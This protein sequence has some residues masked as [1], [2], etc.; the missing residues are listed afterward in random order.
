MDLDHLQALMGDVGEPESAASLDSQR[1]IWVAAG[2]NRETIRKSS[3]LLTPARELAT[4]L[5]AY[6]R[7]VL[8]GNQLEN[9][10]EEFIQL[11]ADGV[12]LVDNP[13]LAS[14]A[15]E[16]M[17]DVLARLFQEHDPAVVLF[18]AGSWGDPLAAGL[19]QR[20]R[21]PLTAG[22]VAL[23]PDLATR[24]ISAEYVVYGGEYYESRSW[25]PDQASRAGELAQLFTLMPAAYRSPAPDPYRSGSVEPVTVTPGSTQPRVRR[26][27][28]ADHQ[29][30]A[31]PIS[32]ASRLVAVGFDLGETNLPAAQALADKLGAQLCGDRTAAAAGWISYNQVVGLTGYDVAPEL[33]L[34]LGV[35]GSTE[36]NIGLER[37]RH[38]IAIH[39]D[40]NAP[41]FQTADLCLVA[42]PAEVLAHLEKAVAGSG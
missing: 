27:G 23:R 21:A 28:P 9:L 8:L 12:H 42:E 3:W 32:T 25:L 4:D 18:P 22:C 41:I 17:Q 1:D 24:A 35:R 11:G 29:R 2:G 36:H 38:V 13:T 39:P 31:T 15:P 14:A 40:R 5:G 37:A 34:A 7:A 19:A 30:P 10:A 33:Y 16:L 20:L 26:I 6:V